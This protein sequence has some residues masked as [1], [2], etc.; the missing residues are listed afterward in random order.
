[1][2]IRNT[3]WHSQAES[4]SDDAH[5]VVRR[6]SVNGATRV[7]GSAVLDCGEAEPLAQEPASKHQDRDCGKAGGEADPNPDA[8][9]VV[10]E[11]QPRAGAEADDPI[12]DQRE[13]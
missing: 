6:S 3:H 9:P 11:G 7:C 4:A 10:A 13:D 12:A 1:M 2:L 8:L 5:M